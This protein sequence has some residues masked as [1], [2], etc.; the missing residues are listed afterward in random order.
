MAHDS[1]GDIYKKVK[2]SKTVV[3]DLNLD[4]KKKDEFFS[5]V[6]CAHPPLS[7]LEFLKKSAHNTWYF[8]VVLEG[9]F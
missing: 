1:F 4:Q 5:H 7:G 2:T 3:D 6:Y 9:Q 8:T